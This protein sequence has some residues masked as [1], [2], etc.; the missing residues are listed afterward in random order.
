MQV[1]SETQSYVL[2]Q[3]FTFPIHFYSSF[4]KLSNNKV[5]FLS[6]ANPTPHCICLSFQ[7]PPMLIGPRQKKVQL[8]PGHLRNILTSKTHYGCNEQKS[9]LVILRTLCVHSTT[10]KGNKFKSIQ[11]YNFACLPISPRPSWWAPYLACGVRRVT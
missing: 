4:R 3:T 11:G 10:Q 8:T 7:Q 1:G 6:N 9:M 2:F 5:H